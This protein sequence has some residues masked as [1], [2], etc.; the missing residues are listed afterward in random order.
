M[1]IPYSCKVN[2]ILKIKLFCDPCALHCTFETT[3]VCDVCCYRSVKG[4]L[5]WQGLTKQ[6]FLFYLKPFQSTQMLKKG[7]VISTNTLAE[8]FLQLLHFT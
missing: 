3:A 8:M 4:M 6:I 1:Q 7:E 2:K 5:L